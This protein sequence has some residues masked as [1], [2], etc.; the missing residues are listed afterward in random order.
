[1]NVKLYDFDLASRLFARRGRLLSIFNVRHRNNFKEN[2]AE[3]VRF[4]STV[5]RWSNT[6]LERERSFYDSY[7]VLTRAVS[8][9]CVPRTHANDEFNK[10]NPKQIDLINRIELYLDEARE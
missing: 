3:S 8:R 2:V 7:H 10:A 6:I 5:L 4:L 9:N 1:M